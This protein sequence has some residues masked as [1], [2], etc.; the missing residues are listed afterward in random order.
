M[1]LYGL[2][3]G[4]DCTCIWPRTRFLQSIWLVRSRLLFGQ[5][6]KGQVLCRVGKDIAV[7]QRPGVKFFDGT[8]HPPVHWV[9]C[10]VLPMQHLLYCHLVRNPFWVHRDH[11]VNFEL[12]TSGYLLYN[13]DSR[14]FIIVQRIRFLYFIFSS[15]FKTVYLPL[16]YFPRDQVVAQSILV[17]IPCK[18]LYRKMFQ[19]F[20]FYGKKDC[21]KECFIPLT[22]PMKY[23][24]SM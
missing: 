7:L 6:E 17:L 3:V 18:G 14:K 23:W 19:P 10:Q 22:L 8:G 12:F 15:I 21:F 13:P 2:C 5:A 20:L 4:C 1:W 9:H 11:H 16:S 24:F